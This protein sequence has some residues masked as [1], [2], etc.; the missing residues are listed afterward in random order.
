MLV[1]RGI[2]KK[3]QVSFLLSEDHP[4]YHEKTTFLSEWGVF[5]AVVMSLAWRQCQLHFKESSKIFLQILYQHLCR[6][7]GMICSIQQENWSLHSS[8]TMFRKV[9]IGKIKSKSS[10]MCIWCYKWNDVRSYCEPGGH[11]RRPRQGESSNLGTYADKCLST[12]LGF[13]AK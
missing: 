3:I 9:S 10:Q 2:F 13:W 11:C 7:F 8:A 12:K 4:E 6:Y 1:E 5:V